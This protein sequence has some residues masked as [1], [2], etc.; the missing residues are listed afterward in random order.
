M[1]GH[2]NLNV[3]F[4]DSVSDSIVAKVGVHRADMDVLKKLTLSLL[5]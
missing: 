5:C 2:N 4:V 1:A 3:G